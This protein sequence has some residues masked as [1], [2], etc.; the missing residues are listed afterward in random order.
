MSGT[1]FHTNH[2]TPS[3]VPLAVMGWLADNSAC[4][5]YRLIQPMK[6]LAQTYGVQVEVGE[7]NQYPFTV[8][9]AQ[10]SHKPEV[11]EILRIIKENRRSVNDVGVPKLIYEIDDNLWAIEPDN[12]AYNYYHSDG[13]LD[14]AAEAAS[15]ADAVTVSTWPLAEVMSQ[16]NDNVHVLP[17][18]IPDRLLNEVAFP[19]TAGNAGKPYVIAW[20]GSATHLKDFRQCVS[21]LNTVLR[22]IPNSRMVF[23][24]TDYSRLLDPSVAGQVRVAPWTKTVGEYHNLLGQAQIDVMLAPL[25]P[26]EFNESKSDLRIIE[27]NALGIPVIATNFGPYRNPSVVDG[28]NGIHV[29]INDSWVPALMELNNPIKRMDMSAKAREHASTLSQSATIDRWLS[30]YDEVLSA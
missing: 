3:G 29:G 22:L 27:A 4:G 10:R 21:G 28:H 16:Y 5:Y 14:R 7:T 1:T 30:T 19:Y 20:A 12:P 13:N 17:N 9:V 2:V 26:S 23:F 25:A 18:S 15:L 24:G 6:A 11:L 8:L